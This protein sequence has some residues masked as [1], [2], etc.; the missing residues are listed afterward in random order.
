MDTSSDAS[1]SF[2]CLSLTTTKLTLRN[3]KELNKK[4]I[5]EQDSQD[6][7]KIDDHVTKSSG[8][9]RQYIHNRKV[10]HPH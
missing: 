9:N 1:E 8:R 5:N 6:E 2:I 3:K 10:T 7:G 4:L